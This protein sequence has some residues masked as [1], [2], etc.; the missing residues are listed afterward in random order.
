VGPGKP[1]K[2]HQFKKGQSGNPLGARLRKRSIVP[3]LK[4]MLQRALN[5]KMPNTKGEKILTKAAAGIR[6]LVDQFACGDKTARRDLIQ[7]AEKLGVDL[8][9]GDAL[10]DSVAVAMTRNDQELIDDFI[11]DYLAERDAFK[12][13]TS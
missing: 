13:H 2:E 5:E 10:A 11:E 8:T 12:R 9:P 1:P 7:I 4:L 6:E 3:D